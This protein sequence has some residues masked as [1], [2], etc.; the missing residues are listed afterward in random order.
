ATPEIS[1]ASLISNVSSN[2]PAGYVVNDNTVAP[3]SVLY[4]QLSLARFGQSFN[5]P[6]TAAQTLTASQ[7]QSIFDHATVSFEGDGAGTFNDLK[8]S[9]YNNHNA[10]NGSFSQWLNSYN[11]DRFFGSKGNQYYTALVNNFKNNATLQKV[12]NG[13]TISQADFVKAFNDATKGL[14]TTD[15]AILVHHSDNTTLGTADALTL[16]YVNTRGSLTLTP[17]TQLNFVFSISDNGGNGFTGT[18]TANG[19]HGDYGQ[20]NWNYPASVAVQSNSR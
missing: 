17:D 14:G 19:F 13:G 9:T 2:A 3:S 5:V 11:G 6:V 16:S 8:Y 7:L 1:L 12:A 18:N 20:N 4:G 15:G 10:T